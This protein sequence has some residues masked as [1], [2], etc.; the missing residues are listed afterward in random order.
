MYIYLL[1]KILK[2]KACIVVDDYDKMSQLKEKISQICLSDE[3]YTFYL[4]DKSVMLQN[5]LTVQIWDKSINQFIIPFQLVSLLK[6]KK[7][8]VGY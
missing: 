5:S 1:R 6:L 4:Y 7:Q 3:I 2:K 8:R